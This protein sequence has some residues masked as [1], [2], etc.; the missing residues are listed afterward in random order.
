MAAM[1]LSSVIGC[2]SG[3]ST[4]PPV[5]SGPPFLVIAGGGTTDT[6][7][8]RLSQALIMEV[9]D[10]TGRLARG[11]TVRFEALPPTDPNRRFDPQIA[12]SSITGSQYGTL[13]TDVTDS[14]GRARALIAFAI[15]AGTARVRVHAPDLGTSDTVTFTVNPGQPRAIIIGTRDTTVQPGAT[16]SLNATLTDRFLNRTSAGIPS[17]SAGPGVVSVSS[18]G[19]VTV[20]TTSVR[21]HIALSWQNIS[22]TAFVSVLERHPLV[23]VDRDYGLVRVATDGTGNVKLVPG[24]GS[25]SPHAV[26]ATNDIVYYRRDPTFDATLWIVT[27]S[28][29]SRMLAGPPDGFVIAAWPRWSP[30][31]TWVYFVGGRQPG[32]RHLWRVRP[33]GTQ[34][35][36]LGTV[37]SSLIYSAASISPDGTTAA[38]SDDM[39]VKLITVATKAT[40]IVSVPCGFVRHSPDGLRFA[41]I[42]DGALWVMNA[43]GTARRKLSPEFEMDDLSGVD[44]SADGQWLIVVSSYAGPQLVRVQDGSTLRLTSLVPGT[45]QLSFVR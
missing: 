20:G 28:G 4:E 41:C 40:N 19:Q 42:N 34:F 43:D 39:G 35:D 8:A 14:A 38:V 3:G 9:R 27:P 18:T 23:G 30:D 15:V 45:F 1:V 6:V 29:T 21:S 22:D 24:G 33:D 32:A 31:G 36:S 17:Y 11:R 7:E 37:T 25:F 13:S 44:W 10:S 26:T 12:V 2:G 16:Y 5:E